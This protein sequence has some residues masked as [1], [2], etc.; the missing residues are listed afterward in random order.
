MDVIGTIAKV[1]SPILLSAK[2]VLPSAFSSSRPSIK[3]HLLSA[4]EI[5]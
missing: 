4:S 2:N 3:R 1:S 5:T